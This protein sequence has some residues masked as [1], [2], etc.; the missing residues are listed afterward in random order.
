MADQRFGELLVSRMDN[1]VFGAFPAISL[2]LSGLIDRPRAA[3]RCRDPCGDRID[4]DGFPRR[5]PS[6]EARGQHRRHTGLI[7]TDT[8]AEK[9]SGDP[10]KPAL[11]LRSPPGFLDPVLGEP[12]GPV[13]FPLPLVVPGDGADTASGEIASRPGDTVALSEDV[14]GFPAIADRER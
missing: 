13:R 8:E 9:V 3:R 7:A 2:G 14:A 1:V 12:F 11:G 4:R 6:I 5:Q 10:V